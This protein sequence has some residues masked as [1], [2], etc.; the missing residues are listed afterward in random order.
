MTSFDTARTTIYEPRPERRSTTSLREIRRGHTH[1]GLIDIFRLCKDLFSIAIQATAVVV[2]LNWGWS[3]AGLPALTQEAPPAAPSSATSETSPAA[4]A[5]APND[6]P[7]HPPE[8]VATDKGPPDS[9]P[10]DKPGRSARSI[11]TKAIK[12]R[13]AGTGTL[14]VS[15]GPDATPSRITIDGRDH[16]YTPILT[17][18][19]AGKHRVQLTWP[20]GKILERVIEVQDGEVVK[21]IGLSLTSSRTT[22]RPPLPKAS[23]E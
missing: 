14:G 7:S 5:Q 23:P 17:Q 19:A 1:V 18:V 16:G 3:Q 15:H 2:V 6:T 22:S 20:D 21:S 9:T 13:S 12:N 4:L 10:I 8:R 11:R